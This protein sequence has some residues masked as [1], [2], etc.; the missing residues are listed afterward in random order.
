[1]RLEAPALPFSKM[2]RPPSQSR[3][4]R[5]ADSNSIELPTAIV[6]RHVERLKSAKETVGN[7]HT[8]IPIGQNAPF[9]TYSLG[10]SR[11]CLVEEHNGANVAILGWP[12][13]L[14]ISIGQKVI[15]CP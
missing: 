15:P 5:A 12:K 13:T 6:C 3:F 1:M 14:A 9:S 4:S 10:G 2:C 7:W 11:D 8:C